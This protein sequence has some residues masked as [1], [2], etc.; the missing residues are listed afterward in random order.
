[1]SDIKITVEAG[2]V[3]N[4][5]VGADAPRVT[6]CNV[7]APSLVADGLA[8]FAARAA[9]KIPEPYKAEARDADPTRPYLTLDLI[10]AGNDVIARAAD[11]AAAAKAWEI[12]EA[13]IS[14]LV[15]ADIVTIGR[16][17]AIAGRHADDLMAIGF[18]SVMISSADGQRH[19]DLLE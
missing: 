8:D 9:T 10:S 11:G 16:L 15:D 13:P 17:N 2:A 4:L 19:V 1:M 7:D 12:L 6:T 5:H 3:L 18:G 14:R